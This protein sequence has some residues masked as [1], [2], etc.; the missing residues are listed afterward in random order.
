MSS[1]EAGKGNPAAAGGLKEGEKG[2]KAMKGLKPAM[3]A[4]DPM[5][6]PPKTN[7]PHRYPSSF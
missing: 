6:K 1:V 5:T 4:G 2:M 7:G 3:K